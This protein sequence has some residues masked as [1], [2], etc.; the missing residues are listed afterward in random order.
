MDI[1]TLVCISL[2]AIAAVFHVS[3]NGTKSIV[4]AADGLE[5]I[6]QRS[7]E[8]DMGITRRRRC[9]IANTE[10]FY[11]AIV[12][13]SAGPRYDGYSEVK[14]ALMAPGD[15]KARV[16][17]LESGILASLNGLQAPPSEKRIELLVIDSEHFPTHYFGVVNR[18]PDGRWNMRSDS[19]IREGPMTTDTL[20]VGMGI[21]KHA[22]ELQSQLPI[23]QVAIVQ[24]MLQRESADRPLQVGEPFSILRITGPTAEWIERGACGQKVVPD[25]K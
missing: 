23:E 1:S 9:K 7:G 14:R 22:A 13:L 3:P 12:G 25:A 11:Y 8:V 6:V 2:T 4:V 5:T 20:F 18:E 10:A 24:E 21:G 16:A 19:G 15:F 17:R